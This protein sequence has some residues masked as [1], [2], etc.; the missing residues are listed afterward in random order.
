MELGLEPIQDRWDLLKLC[1]QRR[2]NHMDVELPLGHAPRYPVVVARHI[3]NAAFV[4]ETFAPRVPLSLLNYVVRNIWI[5]L[6]SAQTNGWATNGHV[7]ANNFS[8]IRSLLA[9]PLPAFQTT[10]KGELWSRTFQQWRR[11]W[12]NKPTLQRLCAALPA[13]DHRAAKLHM[14]VYLCTSTIGQGCTLQF[15]FRAGRAPLARLAS[16]I[17][18]RSQPALPDTGLPGL[19]GTRGNSRACTTPLQPL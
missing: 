5:T 17:Q 8:A 9:Q 19:R 10:I 7:H 16:K 18:S 4:H 1:W 6:P 3:E 12:A 13:E 15:L 2:L 11:A 14:R